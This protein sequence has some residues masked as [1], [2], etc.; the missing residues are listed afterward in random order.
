MIS[1]I[2]SNPKLGN[3]GN[4]HFFLSKL[5]TKLKFFCLQSFFRFLDLEFHILPK[6]EEKLLILGI[7][8]NGKLGNLGNWQFFY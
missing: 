3:F 7:G 2:E 4:G 1:S 5:I 6:T 8:Q